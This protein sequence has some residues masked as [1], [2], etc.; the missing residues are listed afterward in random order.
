MFFCILQWICPYE[1][2]PNRGIDNVDDAIV[3]Q[4]TSNKMKKVIQMINGESE[5]LI[6]EMKENDPG[7]PIINKQ[8][9]SGQ[10]C[11]VRN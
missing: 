9:S 7:D 5:I 10:E 3:S 11:N 1:K 8:L 4:Q 2:N 6:D